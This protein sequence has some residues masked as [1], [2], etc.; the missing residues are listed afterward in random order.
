MNRKH[1]AFSLVEVIVSIAVTAVI[2]TGATVAYS[3]IS[4]SSTNSMAKSEQTNS[5]RGVSEMMRA[6]FTAA[7]KGASDLNMY[8]IHYMLTD[9]LTGLS[10]ADAG[11]DHNPYFYGVG[12]LD[13]ET[14]GNKNFSKVT[15]QWFEFDADDE[16]A[17][18]TFFVSLT[19]GAWD[20]SGGYVDA[21]TL[22]TAKQEYVDSLQP[23]DFIVLY[24]VG[25]MYEA[26]AYDNVAIWN[27][28][29]QDQNNDPA[30]EAVILQVD[31]IGD[32]AANEGYDDLTFKKSITFRDDV[33]MTTFPSEDY[34]MKPD[35]TEPLGTN[36][37]DQVNNMGHPPAATFMVR[38]LGPE[39]AYQR[40]EYF[41]QQTPGQEKYSLIRSAN[42]GTKTMTEEVVVSNVTT[43][44]IRLGL[45]VP[46]NI[47]P[48]DVVRDDMDGYVSNTDVNNWTMGLAVSEPYGLPEFDGS[49]SPR[50]FKIIIGRHA[51]MADVLFETSGDDVFDNSFERGFRQQYRIYNNTL[52]MPSL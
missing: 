28:G 8:N 33:V 5:L 29:L 7:G 11:A 46:V 45:D 22:S 16:T 25:V 13:Y 37:V 35:V 30:G 21:L 39:D 38:R 27:A 9:E 26:S 34:R 47:L 18:P 15:L 44:D 31:T 1:K 36:L 40:V 4:R 32:A 20:N 41:V 24:R 52:P 42:N 50:E 6:D 2:V 49:F 23:G 19:N 3:Q 17:Q 12:N 48:E 51:L 43:F 14:V 10:P